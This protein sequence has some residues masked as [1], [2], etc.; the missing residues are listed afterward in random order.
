METVTR[1]D[2]AVSLYGSNNIKKFN[3]HD[4][5]LI[6]NTETIIYSIK[7]DIA[8]C[9]IINEDLTLT[10]CYVAKV[11][12][13]FA[14]G[15][16]IKKALA[17]A[18]AKFNNN[19]SE[20]EKIDMFKKTFK[21]EAK[22]QAEDFYTWH[23]TLTGSCSMGRDSF[24]KSRSISMEQKMTVKEFINLTQNEYNGG[25]IKKLAKFY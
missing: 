23:H 10:P 1:T 18:Q 25:I 7:G 17:D 19:L 9:A 11:G 20:E 4:V 12:G 8:Q 5:F 24:M 3:G 16:T 6:D 15:A 22:Y 13:Y 2:D 21:K 14:H